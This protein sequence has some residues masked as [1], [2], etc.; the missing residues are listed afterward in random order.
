[1]V[2][3]QWDIHRQKTNLRLY[4]KVNSKW[5]IYQIATF[6]TTDYSLPL[7]A[8]PSLSIKCGHAMEGDKDQGNLDHCFAD[9]C[10]K[11]HVWELPIQLSRSL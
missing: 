2:L 10:F 1:M 9:N 11:A 3:K 8:L 5:I 4:T 6:D 7:K